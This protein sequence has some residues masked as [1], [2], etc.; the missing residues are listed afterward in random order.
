[1]SSLCLQRLFHILDVFELVVP[2]KLLI[3]GVVPFINDCGIIL[4][5]MHFINITSLKQ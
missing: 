3:H 1:M 5:I 2:F 4:L